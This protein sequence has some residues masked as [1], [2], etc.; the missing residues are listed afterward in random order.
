MT[1]TPKE[2]FS[3]VMFIIWFVVSSDIFV[4]KCCGQEPSLFGLREW[5]KGE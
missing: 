2:M 3:L 5:Y 4:A 1:I